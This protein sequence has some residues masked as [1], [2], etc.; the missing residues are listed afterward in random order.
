MKYR[1]ITAVFLSSTMLASTVYAQEKAVKEAEEKV[2]EPLLIRIGSI[3]NEQPIPE[4]FAY[5]VPDGEG[6]TKD[7]DNL[8]PTIRW[9]GAPPETKSYV[10]L[11]VDKDVPA[12]FK[13]ANQKGKTISKK[14]KR[15]DFYHWVM[16]DIPTHITSIPQGE[17]SEGVIEG[18]KELGKT[19]YG[20][21]GRNDYATFMEGTYGGYDGPCPPWN[22]ERIHNYHFNVYAL[23]TKTLEL[24]EG[25][26]GSDVIKAMDGHILTQ[27][28]IVGTYTTNAVLLE[29]AEKA[30]AAAKEA[31]AKAKAD[32]KKDK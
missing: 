12:S 15:K 24:E 10:L 18:G 16:T 31:E 13:R 27:G 11:M 9:S 21:N 19:V 8:N 4:K 3:K 26:T 7:G 25:F 23:D 32:A 2:V 22:D 14:A 5:C 28:E 20:T 30:K 17:A 1:V 29:A 6:K